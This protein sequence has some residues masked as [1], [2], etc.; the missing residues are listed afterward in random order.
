MV[1]AIIAML[2]GL[3]VPAVQKVRAAAA[4]TQCINNLKQLGVAL[5]NFHSSRKAF[6]PALGQPY[7]EN[8]APG[9]PANTVPTN[10]PIPWTKAIA[11]FAEQPLAPYTMAVDVF[12]CPSD[13]RGL[14]GLV[15]P[16]DKH[17]YNSYLG[18]AGDTPF[19]T[20]GCFP[21]STNGTTPT[22]AIRAEHITDGTSNT[23]MLAERPPLLLGPN[24]GWGWWISADMGDICIGTKSGVNLS[25]GTGS[26]CNGTVAQFGLPVSRPDTAT[27]ICFI[28]GVG[29]GFNVAACHVQHPFSFHDGGANFLLADGAVRFM[30]YNA[31]L[32]VTAMGTRAGNEVISLPD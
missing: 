16:I 7:S 23:I 26:D 27:D 31:G 1:I 3:L 30:S 29:G 18:V 20:T 11:P 32:V 21:N 17:G 24:W 5:H 2:I 6:P 14:A 28:G 13:P 15:N 12:N 9:A 4:R 25:T 8:G 19:D 22:P 10:W